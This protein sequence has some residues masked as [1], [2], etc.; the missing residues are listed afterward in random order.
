MN[1]NFENVIFVFLYIHQFFNIFLL[2][3]L[4]QPGGKTKCD[5]AEKIE[6]ANFV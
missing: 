5:F 3:N 6:N 4:L 1:C 2:Q